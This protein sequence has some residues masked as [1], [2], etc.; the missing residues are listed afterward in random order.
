MPET[1]GREAPSSIS[2][3]CLCLWRSRLLIKIAVFN[4]RELAGI[5]LELGLDFIP[6]SGE[7]RAWAGIMHN[8]LP[9]RISAQLGQDVEQVLRQAFTF[10]GRQGLDGRF[11]VRAL[12]GFRVVQ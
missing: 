2:R 10:R 8:A 9:L 7:C 4:L 12:P 3:S 11:N 1:G 6:Q 5:G